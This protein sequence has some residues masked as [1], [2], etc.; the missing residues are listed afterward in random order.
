MFALTQQ[1]DLSRTSKHVS[2]APK[3]EIDELLDFD[4]PRGAP[5]ES[6]LLFTDFSVASGEHT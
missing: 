2:L 3:S 5:Q 1:V 6:T 4:R